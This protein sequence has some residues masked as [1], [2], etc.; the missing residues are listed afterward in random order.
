[1]CGSETFAIEV[2]ST[3][4]NV[5]K[6]TVIAITQGLTVPSGLLS[7]AKILCLIARV[8]DPASCTYISYVRLPCSLSLFPRLVREH[9]RVH[10]HPWPQHRLFWR[11]GIQHNLHRNTLHYFD[12]IPSSIFRGQQAQHRT[13]RAG[14]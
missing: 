7:L 5:A 2:S 4:M 1:M 8:L 10:V 3:S 12:V 11:D 13:R 14:D 6:V 9:R